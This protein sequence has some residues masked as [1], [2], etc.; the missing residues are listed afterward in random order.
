MDISK[1]LLSSL[2]IILT[3]IVLL[4]LMKNKITGQKVTIT[5]KK[6]SLNLE[7]ANTEAKRQRGLSNRDSLPE[8]TGLLFIFPTSDIHAFWNY[9]MKFPIDVLWIDDGII[10]KIS[11]LPIDT[12]QP[13][14]YTPK[15]KAKYVLEVNQGLVKRYQWK[16]GDRVI[17]NSKIKN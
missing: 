16:V 17:I 15:E 4:F 8:D 12:G 13:V 14:T 9:H 5:I 11:S 10:K 2:F 6:R 7:I 1:K 3:I